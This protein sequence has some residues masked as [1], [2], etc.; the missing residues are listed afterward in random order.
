MQLECIQKIYK[1]S[2]GPESSV[3]I[4][5][6][7]EDHHLGDHHHPCYEDKVLRRDMDQPLRSA[8][9]PAIL[10]F[11]AGGFLCGL[12]VGEVNFVGNIAI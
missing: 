1:N 5:N 4:D 8:T 7:P 3:R 10:S 9:S 6:N 2:R 11:T 12:G